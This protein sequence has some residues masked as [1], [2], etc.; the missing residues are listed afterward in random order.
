[1][2]FSILLEVTAL[3]TTGDEIITVRDQDTRSHGS[4][5]FPGKRGRS[6]DPLPAQASFW[7]EN[8]VDHKKIVLCTCLLMA[9][10]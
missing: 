6:T 7:W 10:F 9:S 2:L 8:N 4:A 3:I 5:P 1:M